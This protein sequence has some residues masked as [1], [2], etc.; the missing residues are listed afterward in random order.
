ME[1]PRVDMYTL[2]LYNPIITYF[3]LQL[4]LYSF[5]HFQLKTSP[6]PLPAHPA[7]YP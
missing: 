5:K 4:R 6:F 7:F 1:D 3:A 2:L